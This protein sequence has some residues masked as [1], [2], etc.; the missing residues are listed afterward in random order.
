MILLR[1]KCLLGKIPFE[2]DLATGGSLWN[3]AGSN[4]T[5]IHGASRLLSRHLCRRTLG[6]GWTPG[7]PPLPLAPWTLRR[8]RRAALPI[9]A[10]P[11]RTSSRGFLLLPVAWWLTLA[12]P[13]KHKPS[14]LLWPSPWLS[15]QGLGPFLLPRLLQARP[16]RS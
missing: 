13:T 15:G 3:G 12:V 11:G 4:G 1:G 6:L 5:Q 14:G 7:F 16:G 8:G 10:S 9:E 2:P